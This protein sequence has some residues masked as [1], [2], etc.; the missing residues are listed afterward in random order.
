MTVI[1]KEFAKTECV[2]KPITSSQAVTYAQM[3]E[4]AIFHRHSAYASYNIPYTWQDKNGYLPNTSHMYHCLNI[5][6]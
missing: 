6:H 5:T 3:N 2:R 1:F 4:P